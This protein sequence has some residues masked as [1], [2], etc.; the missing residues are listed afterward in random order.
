MSFG[1]GENGAPALRTIPH[2]FSGDS[3]SRDQPH[4]SSTTSDST[5]G[6]AWDAS[7]TALANGGADVSN[8]GAAG[9]APSPGTLF[10]SHTV[11]HLASV[12]TDQF[13]TVAEGETRTVHMR[14]EP[15]ELGEMLIT[16]HRNS[17][18]QLD[19]SIS[20]SQPDTQML[21]QQHSPEIVQALG[22]QGVNVSQ[23][24]LSQGQAGS[25]DSG[26]QQQQAELN[27]LKA[28]LRNGTTART[29]DPV[30]D[31]G[32]VSFRA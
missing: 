24:D 23:F 4:D 6:I 9:A 32:T 7:L 15:P 13:Q 14:V 16:L 1:L 25:H 22:D 17:S 3:A 12:V 10:S 8:A 21:L 26:S 11:D 19:V 5:S 18:G 20:A 27:Q 29:P 31:S 30:R 28:E 2:D